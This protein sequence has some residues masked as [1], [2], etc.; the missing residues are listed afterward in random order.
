[1]VQQFDFSRFASGLRILFTLLMLTTAAASNPAKASKGYE[2][3]QG[4]RTLDGLI[5]AA[6]TPEGSLLWRFDLD[7]SGKDEILF[8][9]IHAVLLSD[10]LGSNPI[11]L[12]RALVGPTRILNLK[13]LGEHLMIEQAN[14]EFRASSEN[15]EER[16]AVEQ[17]FARAILWRGK[18]KGFDNEG[19]W[20]VDVTS[21]LT[22]DHLGIAGQLRARGGGNFRL[23][24]ARS[25]FDP[26]ASLGFPDNHEYDATLT[27]TSD[28]PGREV[29]AVAADPKIVSLKVHHS[30]VALPDDAYAVRHTHPRMGA[31][32][33]PVMDFGA[34]L[35]AR[36]YRQLA[37]RHRLT[38]TVAEDGTI[39][40]ENPI[41]YY[42]D[43]GAPP[44]IRDALLDG[45]R[46][47][48]DAFA[49]AGFPGG[50]TVEL[51]PEDA[52]P[53]DIRYNVINWVHRQTRGWSYGA[54][55]VD[56]RSG[57]ILKGN[58]LLGSQR[59]RQDRRIFE[60]LL[61]TAKTGSGDADDPIT[62]SLARIRQLSAHEVGHTLGLLHNFSASTR[63]RASVMDYPA[64]F[65][66]ATDAGTLNVS[67]AYAT[68]IGEWDKFAITA[69]YGEF[70]N[71][72][73]LAAYIDKSYAD[74]LVFISDAHSRNVGDPHPAASLWDNGADSVAELRNTLAV[75]KIALAQF[76]EDR[77]AEGRPLSD[78]KRVFVP[79]YL[80]HRY[81]LEA[82]AKLI[83]GVDFDYKSRG[84]S[85]KTASPVAVERQR[86]AL[87]AILDARSPA[88]LVIAPEV[89]ALMV[90]TATGFF[91]DPD[92]REIFDTR[93]GTTF[94]PLVA[95]E[96][97]SAIAYKALFHPR[98]LARL[99]VAPGEYQTKFALGDYLETIVDATFEAQ[100]NRAAQRIA[101]RQQD[102]L[103]DALIELA[104]HEATG[105]Y[106][107]ELEAVLEGLRNTLTESRQRRTS[108]P[109]A[110][111]L[112]RRIIRFLD[113]PFDAQKDKP[114]DAPI[115]PGS[116]IGA[117]SPMFL[118]TCWHCDDLPAAEPGRWWVTTGGQTDLSK[119]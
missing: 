17:S 115:P 59:V 82:A 90:P 113:R 37:R 33:Q 87:T 62:L 106:R 10:G 78:L 21:F 80:Y 101:E 27:F 22:R 92:Q 50:F 7:E 25:F 75:R 45:A 98:R 96:A 47:W 49:A 86:E 36:L 108:R 72:A 13:K 97:A 117:A 19:R 11:G 5:D 104:G 54:S 77:V 58:V 109:T 1:M 52:H 55:V 102:M 41:R 31:I 30:L 69:L 70:E 111:M 100:E 8:S 103:V 46:W 9:M 83:G 74:G 39:T 64:P 71:E 26:N 2:Y 60:G 40:V 18:A 118:E 76:A 51:L 81:Q 68:G 107:A 35:E 94:D 73:A 105:P 61:G 15:A 89:S 23:D 44:Q 6:I 12:D 66:R 32:G 63:D 95:A 28:K 85:A 65:V 16:Q 42:V 67:E 29:R 119:P 112:A 24:Q 48:A 114:A 88:A 14:P 79:I 20:V 3:P 57:E 43:R 38:R 116:P 84:D 91:G 93:G 34:P 53:L 110:R 99:A 4:T 56:P